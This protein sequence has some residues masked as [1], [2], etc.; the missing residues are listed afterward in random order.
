MPFIVG[1]QLLRR[2]GNVGMVTV[3]LTGPTLLHGLPVGRSARICKIVA[4]NNSGAPAVLTLGTLSALGV[5]TAMMPSLYA[6][7]GLD[8]IWTEQEIPA[9]EWIKYSVLVVGMTGDIWISSSVAGPQ[10]VIE[11]EEKF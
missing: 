6:L 10:V 5:F 7:N 8:N 2:D 9:V 11:V 3:T 4:Y 1:Q